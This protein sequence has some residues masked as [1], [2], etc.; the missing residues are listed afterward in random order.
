MRD[1]RLRTHD[2]PVH[3]LV[4]PTFTVVISRMMQTIRRRHVG[5][6]NARYRR[7]G[8]LWDGRFKAALVDTDRDPL[9]CH[10]YIAR[11]PVRAHMTG[12]PASYR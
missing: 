11:T 6:F 7:I 2:H 12:D 5:S 10:R 3:V 1:P 9:T 8:T 4:T